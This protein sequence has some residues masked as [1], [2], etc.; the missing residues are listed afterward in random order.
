MG[1]GSFRSP[2]LVPEKLV[3]N[4]HGNAVECGELV[5]CA[6]EHA[7]GARAVVTR[8]VD[9]QGVVKF[10]YVFDGLDD[11]ADLMIRVGQVGPEDVGLFD[12]QLLLLEAKGIPLLPSGDQ[13]GRS[14]Q[15]SSV[16]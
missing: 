9:D 10:A 13:T 16:T 2:E 4:R 7:F 3:L 15:A 12:E 14:T 6:V 5:R 8:D 11:A 1:K